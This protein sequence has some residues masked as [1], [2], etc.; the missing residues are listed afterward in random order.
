MIKESND[1]LRNLNGILKPS[2]IKEQKVL[3]TRLNLYKLL[4]FNQIDI[5]RKYIQQ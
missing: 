2:R 1:F 5:F 4:E 3:H